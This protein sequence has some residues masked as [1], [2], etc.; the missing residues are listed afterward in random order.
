MNILF[1]RG[2][3]PKDRE[4]PKEILYDSIEAEWEFWKRSDE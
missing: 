4:N 1:L 2:F 3:F